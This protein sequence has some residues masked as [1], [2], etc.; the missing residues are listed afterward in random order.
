MNKWLLEIY[1]NI[2]FVLSAA[3][4]LKYYLWFHDFWQDI[5]IVQLYTEIDVEALKN[6]LYDT[7]QRILQTC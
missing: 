4:F 3:V 6:S 7:W 1:M 2:L 5:R